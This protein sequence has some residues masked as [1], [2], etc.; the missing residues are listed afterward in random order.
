MG[1]ARRESDKTYANTGETSVAITTFGSGGLLVKSQV[2]KF[3]P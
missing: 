1:C 2:G 3:A